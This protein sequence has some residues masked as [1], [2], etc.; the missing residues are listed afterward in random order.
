MG[1]QYHDIKDYLLTE[2]FYVSA[3]LIILLTYLFIFLDVLFTL[4][5]YKGCA[6]LHLWKFV[7]LSFLSPFPVRILVYTSGDIMLY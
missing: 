5:G 3:P 7:V 2:L 1:T 6:G 4:K